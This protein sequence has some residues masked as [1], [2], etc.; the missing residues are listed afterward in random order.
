MERKIKLL[1][2]WGNNLSCWF[3]ILKCW[4]AEL[5]DPESSMLN[6]NLFC[7]SSLGFQNGH[8]T[9]N[10][11][12]L[13]NK[14]SQLSQ[15]PRHVTPSASSCWNIPNH[16]VF[17]E[18][19]LPVKT[20][21]GKADRIYCPSAASFFQGAVLS[22]LCFGTTLEQESPQRGSSHHDHTK[23]SSTCGVFNLLFF[24]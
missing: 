5:F 20:S 16:G 23:T 9:F 13:I 11:S 1:K 15:S 3:I 2:L 21:N 18:H 17:K 24:C 22:F 14:G 12:C 19:P 8:M 4:R 6:G 10:T 7:S